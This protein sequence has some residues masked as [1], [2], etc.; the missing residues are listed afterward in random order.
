MAEFRSRKIYDSCA[1]YAPDGELLCLVK[2]KKARWY[3]DRGL[4]E[5]VDSPYSLAVRLTF[6]PAGKGHAGDTFYLQARPNHCAGCGSDQQ[7]T[8]HHVVPINYRRHFPPEIKGHSSHDLVPLCV[9]CHQAYEA[10]AMRL[11]QRLAVEYCAPLEGVGYSSDPRKA[12]VK[13]AASA[14]LRHSQGQANIPDGRRAEL[15]ALVA[16]LFPGLENDPRVWTAAAGLDTHQVDEDAQRHGQLVVSQ[17]TDLQA[18]IER[19]RRH[20]VETLCPAHMPEHW[21]VDR[22]G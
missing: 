10:E 5:E 1:I 18:F 7:L 14:L 17:L 6:E 2:E 20:F 13:K 22:G 12:R 15:R 19:W 11:K 3:L 4:G 16:D 9:A 8:L 21:R